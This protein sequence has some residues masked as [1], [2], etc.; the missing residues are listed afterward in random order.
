MSRYQKEMTKVHKKKVKKA[1]AQ[2]KAFVAGETKLTDLTTRAKKQ[3]AKRKK[4]ESK[5]A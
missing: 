3:L 4:A 5:T 2:V 1:K